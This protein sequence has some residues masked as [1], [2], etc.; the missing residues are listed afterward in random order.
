MGSGAWK[1][2]RVEKCSSILRTSARLP[3]YE[4]GHD[5]KC[6]RKKLKGWDTSLHRGNTRGS[7]GVRITE[8]LREGRGVR[9]RAGQ[10]GVLE[11]RL[12]QPPSS[13]RLWEEMIQKVY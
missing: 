8:E 2:G 1:A 13:M 5:P 7:Y 12:E 11:T 9:H 10:I 4:R 3:R 6:K